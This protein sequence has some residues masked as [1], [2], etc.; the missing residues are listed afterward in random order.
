MEKKNVYQEVTDKM[1]EILEKGNCPWRMPWKNQGS[2]ASLPINI[3]S[4]KIYRG[5]NTLLLAWSPFES[6]IWGTFKQLK[7]CGKQV[8]KGERATQIVFWKIVDIEKESQDG[9][10]HKDKIPLLKTYHVFNV[11]QCEGFVKELPAEIIVDEKHDEIEEC[12]KIISLFPLGMPKLE[13]SPGKA[14]YNPSRDFISIPSPAD[15]E[16]RE[17]YYQTLF[18]EYVHA[19]GH[20]S[21]LN[22][23]TLVASN[24]FGDDIYSQ[25]ELVAEMGASFLSA[26]SGIL[27]KTIENFSQYNKLISSHH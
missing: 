3:K 20:S 19:T 21:R 12:E 25:E 8:K 9:A 14:F 17:E 22:R 26:F 11:E 18:H 16:Q 2:K 4:K 24:Y 6:N 7:E 5:V 27:P 10:K 13:H 23:E 1:I 15:Y